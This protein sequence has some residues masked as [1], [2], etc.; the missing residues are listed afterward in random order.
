MKADAEAHAEEDKRRR[1]L[2][3]LKNQGDQLISQTR[4]AL[5]EHG[6]KVSGDIR[7]KI[8]SAV[9]NLEDKLKGDDKAPIE[10]AIN[11]LQQASMELGKVVY[12]ATAAQQAAGG[13]QPDSGT[14]SA[15][16]G[17]DVIDAE[18]EVKDDDAKS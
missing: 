10:A 1:E 14:E 12:E 2:V 4:Q 13:A 5:E 3:D 17:D 16:G 9:S 11:E 15:S 6:D 8:E 7:S 18:F